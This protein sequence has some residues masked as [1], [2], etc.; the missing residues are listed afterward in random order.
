MQGRV[1]AATSDRNQNKNPGL[2]GTTKKA[3]LYKYFMSV[4]LLLS[5]NKVQL[6]LIVI[7]MNMIINETL[8]NTV[9]AYF[10]LDRPWG[11]KGQT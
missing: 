5:K 4:I 9:Q 6:L 2:N 10:V 8:N 3:P 7:I 11:K 1:S